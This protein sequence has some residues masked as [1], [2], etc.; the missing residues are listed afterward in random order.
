MFGVML[1]VAL[2]LVMFC[3]WQGCIFIPF[4]LPVHCFMLISCLALIL[5]RFSTL[6][7]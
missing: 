3:F 4:S 5:I 1:L 6:N 7:G 2:N